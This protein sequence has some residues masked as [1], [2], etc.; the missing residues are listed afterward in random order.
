MKPRPS[1]IRDRSILSGSS[2]NP[3]AYASLACPISL[4]F[5]F[6]R[7]SHLTLDVLA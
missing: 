7:I 4:A 6:T 2:G 1:H 3:A 5:L